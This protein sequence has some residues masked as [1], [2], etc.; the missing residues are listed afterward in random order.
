L[1]G[2]AC[3]VW[4]NRHR[5]HRWPFGVQYSADVRPP[6]GRRCI[7][8]LDCAIIF[9]SLRQAGLRSELAVRALVRL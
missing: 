6:L 5:L 7:A 8:L 1:A 2:C 4:T 3:R 9:A